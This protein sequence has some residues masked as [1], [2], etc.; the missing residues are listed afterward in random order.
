M[1]LTDILFTSRH[2]LMVFSRLIASLNIK[3]NYS[4]SCLSDS[5]VSLW[6]VTSPCSLLSFVWVDCKR[7]GESEIFPKL[8]CL[9][10]ITLLVKTLT[11]RGGTIY[12]RM[13]KSTDHSPFCKSFVKVDKKKPINVHWCLFLHW[14]VGYFI[15]D[16][17][18][19]F[20]VVGEFNLIFRFLFPNVQLYANKRISINKCSF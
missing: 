6:L 7:F 5:S 13:F 12:K 20:S 8:R 19:I 9:S 3:F 1:F 18:K 14:A 17:S 16:Y 10:E 2:R 11:L 15:I 4:V